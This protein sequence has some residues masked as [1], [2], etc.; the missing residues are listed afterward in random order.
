MK[1]L[2]QPALIGAFVI[3]ALVLAILGLLLF[4]GGGLLEDRLRF[5][6]FF[7]GSVKGLRVGSPVTFRGVPIG[8]VTDIRVKVN[9]ESLDFIVQVEIETKP[10]AIIPS[11]GKWQMLERFSRYRVVDDL[12]DRGLRAR[13]QSQSFVTGVLGVDLDFY[14]DKPLKLVGQNLDYKELPTIPSS[15]DELTAAVGEVRFKELVDTA[16]HTV[17]G[18]E[19][20][21][22]SPE[23]QGSIKRFDQTL[24][25]L[26]ALIARVD[27]TLP[28]ALTSVDA[29]AQG[30]R[31]VAR[32]LDAVV[33][34]VGRSV[35]QLAAA[36]EKTMGT[37]EQTLQTVQAAADGDTELTY[38][39]QQALKDLSQAA[40]AFRAL[41]ETL[42]THPDALLR[43]KTDLR[44]EP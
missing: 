14:P 34:P 22:N 18:I 32:N 37:L 6:L 20:L 39:L 35:E 21:V 33:Q 25:N 16:I 40:R 29:A 24:Q 41:T 8:S 36:T 23:L 12:I 5:T 7:D 43:G 11:D 27:A 38:E 28:K 19:K 31:T 13:L 3:G 42:E 9:P 44:S 17:E 30:V 26:Q 10:D 4:G 1:K 2:T 15:I